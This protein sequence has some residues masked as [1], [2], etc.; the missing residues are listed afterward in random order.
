MKATKL[1]DQREEFLVEILHRNTLGLVSKEDIREVI[2][3]EKQLGVFDVEK[4][5]KIQINC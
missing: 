1:L 4:S 3:A 2:E 5:I